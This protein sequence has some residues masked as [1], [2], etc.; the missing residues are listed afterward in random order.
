MKQVTAAQV[1][2][3]KVAELG[4]DSSVL[5][6]SSVE[7]IAGALRRAARFLCPCT[8]ATLV[9]GVVQ[10]LRGLVGDME[11][12]KRVVK[13]TLEAMIAYGDILEQRITERDPGTG[14]ATLLYAAPASFVERESGVFMLVGFSAD[15]ASTLPEEFEGR[16]EYV[17]HLRRL[18]AVAGEDLHGELA[19]IGL[20]QLSYE[21]WLKIP[22]ARTAAQHLSALNGLL[23]AAQPSRDVPGLELLDWEKPV[24]YYRGRW[25]QAQSHS[26]RFVARRRQA[27]GSD[28]WSYVEVNHGSPERLIDFPIGDGR[29]RGCDEAWRLQMAID[30]ER[31]QPQRF[32]VG[33]AS[34]C[35]RVIEFFSP[36][37][38]WARRRWDSIGEPIDNRGCLIAYRLPDGEIDQE[39]RFIRQELWLDELPVVSP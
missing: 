32:R 36:V 8:V 1:H 26:G 4:L 13:D 31:G 25:T 33:P 7:A 6:L 5:D 9:R 12:I 18:Q 38:M 15:Q 16:V 14:S 35:T 22:K 29:W 39:T 20:N 28:L 3:R 37:P 10:P 34:Q 30:S 21:R 2:A 17:G 23:D 19:Q 27:Y 11:D 24:R